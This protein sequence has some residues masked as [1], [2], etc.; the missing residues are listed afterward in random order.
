MIWTD[1]KRAIL[2]LG[3]APTAATVNGV[4][5]GTD[6]GGQSLFS[7]DLNLTD[8]N[9][10]I[11]LQGESWVLSTGDAIADDFVIYEVAAGA[12]A[13]AAG[14]L[15][16]LSVGEVTLPQARIEVRQFSTATQAVNAAVACPLEFE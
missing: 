10:Q 3:G 2:D 11:S 14:T 6:Q 5:F 1:F 8:N 7:N 4:Q 9:I 15:L 12:G 16:Q 13:I